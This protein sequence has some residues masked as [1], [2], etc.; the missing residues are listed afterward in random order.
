MRDQEH[1]KKCIAIRDAKPYV[2]GSGHGFTLDE[3]NTVAACPDVSHACLR[4]AAPGM[5]VMLAERARAAS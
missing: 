2:Q 1:T 3:L 4:L 5:R